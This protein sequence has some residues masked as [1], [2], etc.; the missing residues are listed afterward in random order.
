MVA[1]GG[2]SALVRVGVGAIIIG[3][4]TAAEYIT[5]IAVR[6]GEMWRF[7]SS[8]VVFIVC[9]FYVHENV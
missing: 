3:D 5:G 7:T 9:Y 8:T 6:C 2:G 4:W 1:P